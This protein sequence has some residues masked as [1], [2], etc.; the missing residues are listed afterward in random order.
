MIDITTK[1]TSL[2]IA[3]AQA[4][5]KADENTIEFV[6]NNKVPKGNVFEAS[7]VAALFAVKNTSHALPHCHPIPVEFTEVNHE[8]VNNTTIQITVTVKTIYKTGCE[9]EAL[10]GA[11][12][13]ALTMYDRQDNRNNIH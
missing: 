5:I 11:S 6:R 10:H 7:R 8:I 3:R 12:I 4:F 13:A 1:I 9:M 2:R